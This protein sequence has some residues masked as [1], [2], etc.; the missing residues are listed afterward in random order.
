M[1]VGGGRCAFEKS[2]AL[3][4]CGGCSFNCRECSALLLAVLAT[5]IYAQQKANEPTLKFRPASR[6]APLA[7][8][9][10]VVV[11]DKAEN[12]QRGL[13]R[14]DFALLEDAALQARSGPA[15]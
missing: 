7:M 11:T 12:P 1:I 2:L 13:Q 8:D 6:V 5:S 10:Q 15:L 9:L 3:S 4:S 14:S